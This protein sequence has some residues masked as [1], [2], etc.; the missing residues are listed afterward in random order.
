MD[1]VS[2]LR[3]WLQSKAPHLLLEFCLEQ[4]Y[5]V[6]MKGLLMSFMCPKL[7]RLVLDNASFKSKKHIW[8]VCNICDSRFSAEFFKYS[9]PLDF[10]MSN[11]LVRLCISLFYLFL[12]GNLRWRYQTLPLISDLPET[13]NPEPSL[14]PIVMEHG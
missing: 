11:S 1:C 10:W 12:F 5:L 4:A 2:T 9:K 7:D 13:V 8:H 3:R 6:L 14:N